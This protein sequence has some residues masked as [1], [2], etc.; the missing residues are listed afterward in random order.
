MTHSLKSMR[1]E[2][3][4]AENA[5]DLDA[6]CGAERRSMRCRSMERRVMIVPRWIGQSVIG[7]SVAHI[8]YAGIVYSDAWRDIVRRGI[9]DAGES[10][11][12]AGFAVWFAFCGLS[13]W[14]LGWSW[15]A[16]SA[17]RPDRARR[18]VAISMLLTVLAG[19][20]LI[21]AS[22]FWLMLPLALALF[23]PARA[24]SSG[25]HGRDGR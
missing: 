4:R 19:I 13:W 15:L 25:R 5:H 1:V 12:D 21:P 18:I 17:S 16:S 14:V 9:F 6:A 10:S 22:G 11:A 24:T 3:V 8:L 20:L 23:P 7:L 2:R